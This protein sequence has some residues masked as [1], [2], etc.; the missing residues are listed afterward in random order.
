MIHWKLYEI[1][2]SVSIN[3]VSW[4]SGKIKKIPIAAAP[5]KSF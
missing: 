5:A 4:N 3:K 2:M 1:P